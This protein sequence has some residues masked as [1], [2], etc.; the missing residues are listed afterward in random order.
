V[1]CGV[2]WRRF[3]FGWS[4]RRRR[5]C[6]VSGNSA[7]HAHCLV[8]WFIAAAA[9]LLHGLG[10][11]S[12]CATLSA[13]ALLRPR[14]GGGG[15]LVPVQA[16]CGG[17]LAPCVALCGLH[18]PRVASSRGVYRACTERK[19]AR[20]RG[21]S[22]KSKEACPFVSSTGRDCKRQ[23]CLATHPSSAQVYQF[24]YTPSSSSGAERT[25]AHGCWCRPCNTHRMLLLAVIMAGKGSAM[26]AC[27]L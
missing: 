10:R 1:R 16:C 17:R 14:C 2:A 19:R 3:V 13:A 22:V 15:G 23:L 18:V 12:L 21:L 6:R 8:C 11:C 24:S 26:H 25:R 27:M 7:C 4:W 9:L 20:A 5:R